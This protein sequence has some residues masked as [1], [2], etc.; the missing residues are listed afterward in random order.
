MVADDV[1]IR[2]RLAGPRRAVDDEPA[3]RARQPH[4]A[5]L[6]R[7]GERHEPLGRHVARS[8][9][10][11]RAL[12]GA[13]PE[14][15]AGLEE[16][17][18][19]CLRLLA[20]GEGLDVP[21]QRLVRDGKEAEHGAGDDAR[22]TQVLGVRVRNAPER[23]VA[24]EALRRRDFQQRAE[25]PDELLDLPPGLRPVVIGEE[26]GQSLA[27]DLL[28]PRQERGVGD[29]PVGALLRALERDRPWTGRSHRHPHRNERHRRQ[30]ALRAA[31]EAPRP[32]G[33]RRNVEHR[34]A[35]V[36]GMHP[37]VLLVGTRVLRD[38]PQPGEQG[39]LL[40]PI[41]VRRC[42]D[43]RRLPAALPPAPG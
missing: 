19:R 26:L 11:T 24:P 41:H 40:V 12:A 10:H 43:R 18:D 36:K 23:R 3:A 2:L 38:R 20:I 34:I 22:L 5:R 7:I 29:D 4:G 30:D 17:V 14:A 39:L 1:D 42:P 8:L 32:A 31:A 35:D 25:M 6:T 21:E 13:L 28:D 27:R 37:G 16:G 9:K 33:V 15:D